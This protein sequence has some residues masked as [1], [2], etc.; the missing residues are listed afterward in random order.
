MRLVDTAGIRET[1]ELVERLG[2]ERSYEAMAD[3]DLTIVVVDGT[4]HQDRQSDLL[5]AN[6]ESQGKAL[7]R[8]EQVR[9]GRL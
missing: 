8:R 2:I 4:L 3:A 7:D 1:T 6:A 9:S 5:V